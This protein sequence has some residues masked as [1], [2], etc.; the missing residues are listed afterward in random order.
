MLEFI[1][2]EIR[3]GEDARQVENAF[4]SEREHAP[5]KKYY[6]E[7]KYSTRQSSAA[8]LNTVTQVS[9]KSCLFCPQASDH[10]AD[11]CA[12][13]KSLTIVELKDI[14]SKEDACWCCFRKGH[15]KANCRYLS[16]LSC[17][18]CKRQHHTLLHEN[19]TNT[20][21]A[22]C[23]NEVLM[24]IAKG[25]LVG[26]NGKQVEVNISLDPCSDTSFV[27]KETSEV[28]QLKGHMV[29]LSIGGI[30]GHV[31]ESKPRKVVTATIRNRHHLDKYK[32]VN[33][34][35]VPIIFNNIRR[36]AVTKQV[37]EAKY[38]QNLQLADD[39]S[40]ANEC[41]I[42]VLL[43]LPDYYSVV[44]GKV[45]RSP[46]KPIAIDSIF[47]WVLVSDSTNTVN[48]SSNS[49]CL[50]ITTAEE[51]QI[52]QQLKKFW[53]IEECVPEKKMQW[54]PRKTKTFNEFKNSIRYKNK[55]Y[56]V[57]LPM[58]EEEGDVVDNY[59]NKSLASDRFLKTRRRF[60]KK[61]DI[62]AKYTEAV[63]EYNH[64][65]Y[66]ERVLEE[67]EPD[68]C[69]YIPHQIVIKEDSISTKVRLVMDGSAS[70]NRKKKY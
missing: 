50:F 48:P 36:P 39:Y 44:S 37:L 41:N 38:I 55:K 59:S 22:A 53:D 13:A 12:R 2:W 43:G 26:P 4:S 11:Q 60:S 57:K 70:A 34:V 40:S 18:K 68:G 56:K 45:R 58:I 19:K 20:G 31:D 29:D 67:S 42:N 9:K 35:E 52:S 69:W 28:L 7:T 10:Y 61:P 1:E 33:L 51:N 62:G 17:A 24:P 54:T 21:C 15:R 14:L 6:N 32:E 23:T 64:S 63:T 27:D 49:I 25:R 46:E 3:S 8:A 65:G 30:T 5:R 66:A 16:R 47:G